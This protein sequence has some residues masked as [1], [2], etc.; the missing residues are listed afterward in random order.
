M[1]TFFLF[2]ISFLVT[3]HH[4]TSKSTHSNIKI[5]NPKKSQ[6]YPP[7]ISFCIVDLKYKKPHLKICELG[8]GTISGFHGYHR[9]YRI[10]DIWDEFWNFL[11]QFSDA[12]FYINYQQSFDSSIPIKSLATFYNRHGTMCQTVKQLKSNPRFINA[13]KNKTHPIIVAPLN[14]QEF[15]DCCIPTSRYHNAILLDNATRPFVLNKLLTHLLFMHDPSIRHYRPLCKI[16]PTSYSPTM[17]QETITD[18][19][20]SEYVI[21]PINAY[22]GKGL[23]FVPQQELDQTLKSI[24]CPQLDTNVTFSTNHEYW[25]HHPKP[26]FLIESRESSQLIKV[27]E[28]PYDATMRV[29]FGVAYHQGIIDLTFFGAYWKLPKKSIHELGSLAERYQS[30]IEIGSSC[31]TKVN[32]VTYNEVKK[33]LTTILPKIYLK[34]LA[35]RHDPTLIPSLLEQV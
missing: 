34:M 22:K 30:H 9:L 29:A 20:S 24:L 1:L 4:A 3:P 23:I 28:Q 26:Y 17:A 7:D 32:D 18:I 16:F 15:K 11:A 12:I 21:K 25:H 19:P 31:S 33:I 10:G 6:Y 5:N 14:Y 27:A 2:L 35:A 8:Q 13:L